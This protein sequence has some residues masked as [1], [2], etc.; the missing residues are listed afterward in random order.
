MTCAENTRRDRS[1]LWLRQ[2]C[3]VLDLGLLE[4]LGLG[5]RNAFRFRNFFWCRKE[6]GSYLFSWSKAAL[7]PQFMEYLW[8][9]VVEAGFSRGKHTVGPLKKAQWRTNISTKPQAGGGFRVDC[10]L[11]EDIQV[12]QPQM[13][14]IGILRQRPQK[15]QH[16][17]MEE[18]IQAF[19]G[20]DWL[21]PMREG[22]LLKLDV[23]TYSL[24]GDNAPEPQ[25]GWRQSKM[26]TGCILE[27]Y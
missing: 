3:N 14:W 23:F 1:P 8:R 11:R 4:W 7:D 21:L 9:K 17:Y 27:N 20:T 13:G 25:M 2:S 6:M 18:E 16:C 5:I 19:L 24:N 12:L 26:F 22:G 15:E 10:G